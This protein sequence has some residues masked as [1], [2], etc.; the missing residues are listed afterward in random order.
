MHPGRD[1]PIV[2]AGQRPGHDL[3]EDGADDSAVRD[4]IPALEA[5]LQ[6]Q[7]RPGAIV[8][9]VQDDPQS[10]FVERA[11]GEAMVWCDFEPC[12]A[13]DLD[14]PARRGLVRRIPVRWDPVRRTS[15]RRGL[16]R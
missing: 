2:G 8:V 16:V 1:A 4:P 5:W 9:D 15:A 13:R 3:V 7:F 6:G 12:D 10:V 11:A 14:H